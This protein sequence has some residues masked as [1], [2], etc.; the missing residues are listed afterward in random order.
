MHRGCAADVVA[1]ADFVLV[2]VLKV[3]LPVGFDADL[4]ADFDPDLEA[5]FDVDS[6]AL[7]PDDGPSSATDAP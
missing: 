7:A 6:V 5:V 4:E 3:E 1:W 2:A